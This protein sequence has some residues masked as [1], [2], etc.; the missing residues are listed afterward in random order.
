MSTPHYARDPLRFTN[1]WACLPI[2]SRVTGEGFNHSFAAD[3]LRP[4]AVQPGVNREGEHLAS[5]TCGLKKRQERLES[6]TPLSQRLKIQ[7][8]LSVSQHRPFTDSDAALVTY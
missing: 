8:P 5:L 4:A 2:R 3:V 7:D 6:S 1:S